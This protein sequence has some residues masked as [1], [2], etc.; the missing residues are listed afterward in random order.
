MTHTEARVQRHFPWWRV[1]QHHIF[2]FV[3]VFFSTPSCHLI[4][5]L[6]RCARSTGRPS[7]SLPVYIHPGMFPPSRLSSANSSISVSMRTGLIPRLSVPVQQLREEPRGPIGVLG[8]IPLKTRRAQLCSPEDCPARR[9]QTI[10]QA[11]VQKGAWPARQQRRG[12]VQRSDT[13]VSKTGRGDRR[14]AGIAFSS[15]KR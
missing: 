10:R 11:S 15:C 5:R 6:S 7:P 12:P 4:G 8:R 13:L 9:G 3:V 14:R 1:T 2:F